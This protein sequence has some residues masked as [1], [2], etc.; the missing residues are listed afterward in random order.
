MHSCNRLRAATAGQEAGW[1]ISQA[2]VLA[3]EAGRE[4]CAFR[5]GGTI[6][7]GGN[8]YVGRL[9]IHHTG[10]SVGVGGTASSSSR[11]SSICRRSYGD[12]AG[13]SRTASARSDDAT[14][15]WP[16]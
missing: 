5:R 16:P 7:G 9:R 8:F 12:I 10:A 3:R 11:A 6:V 14:A 2:V 13:G 4:G 15:A 1:A